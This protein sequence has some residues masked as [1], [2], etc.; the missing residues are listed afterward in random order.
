MKLILFVLK[1]KKRDSR[2]RKER[3]QLEK[4]SAKLSSAAAPQ[5]ELNDASGISYRIRS[6]RNRFKLKTNRTPLPHS[7]SL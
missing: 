3:K 4:L 5:I 7:E 6:R 1:N 2:K